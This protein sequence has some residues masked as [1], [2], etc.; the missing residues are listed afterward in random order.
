MIIFSRKSF[1]RSFVLKSE[2]M[3]YYDVYGAFAANESTQN[4]NNNKNKTETTTPTK[5]KKTKTKTKF[6]KMK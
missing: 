4:N 1:A 5:K 2:N 6:K 3:A